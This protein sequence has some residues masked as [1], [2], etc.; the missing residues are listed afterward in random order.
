MKTINYKK[1]CYLKKNNLYKLDKYNKHPPT[2]NKLLMT[3]INN[4]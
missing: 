3:I 4:I 2:H 1:N